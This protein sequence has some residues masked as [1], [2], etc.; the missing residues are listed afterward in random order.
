[1]TSKLPSVPTTEAKLMTLMY[2][3]VRA[4]ALYSS[5]VLP[6]GDSTNSITFT[7]V[8]QIAILYSKMI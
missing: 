8:S 6:F 2:G 7:V 4:G 1:M 5:E 3:T